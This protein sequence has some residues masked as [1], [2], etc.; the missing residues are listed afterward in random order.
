MQKQPVTRK[1][2]A[3]DACGSAVKGVVNCDGT[4]VLVKLGTIRQ[5]TGRTWQGTK[6][7]GSETQ[8]NDK[9]HT[10]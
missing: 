3:E 1:D 8:G 2:H 4:A 7:D 10:D 5:L 9:Y 6:D